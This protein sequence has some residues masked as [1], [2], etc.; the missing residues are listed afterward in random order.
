[1]NEA[2]TSIAEIERHKKAVGRLIDILVL[3]Y[4][5][6]LKDW[7]CPHAED[8]LYDCAL[9]WLNYAYTDKEGE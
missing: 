6:P 3:D 1:M 4:R 2:E 5:C 7:E 9:C 8:G